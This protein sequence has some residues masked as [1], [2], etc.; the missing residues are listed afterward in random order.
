LNQLRI[1][2]A[3]STNQLEGGVDRVRIHVFFTLAPI[4]IAASKDDLRHR[5]QSR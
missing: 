3:A 4:G 5:R 1:A 2:Q